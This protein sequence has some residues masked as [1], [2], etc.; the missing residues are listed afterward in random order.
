MRLNGQAA[1]QGGLFVEAP[2]DGRL[3]AQLALLEA[4]RVKVDSAKV[5]TFGGEPYYPLSAIP[6]ARFQLDRQALTLVLEVPPEQFVPSALA[7]MDERP[8]P[9]VAGVGGFLDF[10]LL[11]QAGEDLDQGLNGLA[12]V[13]GFG[14]LAP[15]L[16]LPSRGPDPG[17][18]RHAPRHDADTNPLKF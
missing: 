15:S 18:G 7:A 14:P 8:P 6:G 5:I 3:A 13:G 9:P 2:G 10:D 4:W 1:S 12:E 11:Y 16:Q 17:S